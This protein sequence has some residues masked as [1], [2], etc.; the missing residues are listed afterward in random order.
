MVESRIGRALGRRVPAVFDEGLI[1]PVGNGKAAD[2]EL[3]NKHAMNWTFVSSAGVAAHPELTS[4]DDNH[5]GFDDHCRAQEAVA[6]QFG[7]SALVEQDAVPV[8]DKLTK[9]RDY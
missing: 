8:K 5:V 4:R 1:Q 3:I 2:C 6:T 7:K 9:G